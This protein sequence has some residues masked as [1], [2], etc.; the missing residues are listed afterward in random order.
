MSFSRRRFLAIAA[1]STLSVPGCTKPISRHRF[2]AL[3]ADAE[4]TL[5]GDYDQASAAITACEKE[6]ALVESTFSLYQPDSMLSRLNRNG[7]TRTNKRFSDL[8]HHA[9]YMAQITRGAFD[10]TIQ[11]L[12]QALA[13]DGD[14][15]HARDLI[16]WRDLAISQHSARFKRLG[17]AAS[18]N[19]I[20]QGF[21]A[22]RV[23]A[24]LARHGYN[25]TLVNLGEFAISGSKNGVPWKLGIYNPVTR[26]IATQ[27]DSIA[28]A[29]ATSEPDATRIAGQPHIFDPLDRTGERWASV[30][31]E[32]SEAWRADALS[33][34]VAASP[35]QEAA[36]LLSAGKATRGWMID[37][38]GALNRWTS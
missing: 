19:G 16:S 35:V 20:A 7:S 28:G 36:L 34:A 26:K 14:K 2:R 21:A 4:I 30:T 8:L 32:A 29:I 12:W 3:G 17:M 1:L 27:I 9:L 25:N 6:I 11:A 23:A 37:N 31:V 24:I 33:T 13:I 5:V 38:S 15:K 18:L 10:P 22:D